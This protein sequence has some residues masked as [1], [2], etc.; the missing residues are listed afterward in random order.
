MKKIKIPAKTID[1][2]VD[3]IV[4]GIDNVRVSL[5]NCCSPVF[6][7]DIIGYITK[8]KGITVHKT[9]CHNL[10]TLEI[11][12]VPVA[13]NDTTTKRYLTNLLVYSNTR[14]NHMADMIQKMSMQDISVDSF[15]TIHKTDTIT[16]QI[17]I[18]VKGLDNLNKLI[19]ELDKLPYIQK[20][21]RLMR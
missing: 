19:I 12:T 2:D 16:Y 7:D 1:K 10:S 18:H 11:R 15:Q 6:G 17:S 4:S 14:D 9:N 13:W 21:E 20:I 3:I 5:A 8:G